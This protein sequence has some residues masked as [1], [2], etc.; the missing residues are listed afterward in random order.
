[1]ADWSKRFLG[2]AEAVSRW[3]KDDLTKVGCVIVGPNREIRST[4][5]NGPPRGINDDIEERHKRPEKYFWFEHAERNAIYN[6]AR[7][8]TALTGCAIYTSTFPCAD[9]ARAIVQS[10]IK[11][12]VTGK[13]W[14]DLKRWEKHFNVAMQM[15][16][17]SD[18]KVELYD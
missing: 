13:G 5:Y 8:G 3:S 4:G 18:I 7:V 14:K 16:E 10:G 2:L 11:K 12:V 17:E 9:C 1:M 15:F 6:A